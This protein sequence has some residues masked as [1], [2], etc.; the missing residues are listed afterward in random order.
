MNPPALKT[1]TIEHLRG[2]V[3]P[4]LLEFEAAKNLTL[5]Y[6]ENGTGKSTICD[7][8]ELIGRGT[9]GSLEHRGLGSNVQ[10][11]W[12]SINKRAS[13]ISVTLATQSGECRAV[14]VKK[15]V[16]RTHPETRPSVEVLRRDQI[17][18]LVQATAAER[19][20][21]VAR[22]IGVA[23]TEKSEA[24]LRELRDELEKGRQSAVATLLANQEAIEQHWEGASKPGKDALT[25]AQRELADADASQV[26]A[27]AVGALTG[28]YERLRGR[29][30]E[31]RDGE[32]ALK[33][34]ECCRPL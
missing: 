5:V 8:L 28:A 31:T 19:Y 10:R 6:G 14:I 3:R 2:A 23:G 9:V 13:D 24:A 1:L 11:Y 21:E 26:S 16:T 27:D 30:A 20:G 32:V 34:A 29:L 7:A 12:P 25:W 33:L 15:D 17:L 22:F 4:F 18:T